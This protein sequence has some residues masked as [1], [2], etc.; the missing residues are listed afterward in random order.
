MICWWNV[1]FKCG[2]T[3]TNHVECLDSPNEAVTQEN[4]K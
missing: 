4:I 2:R 3:D 1:D